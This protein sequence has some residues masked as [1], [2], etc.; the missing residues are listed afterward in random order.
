[1]QRSKRRFGLT[2]AM[3]IAAGAGLS[4]GEA[5]AQAPS[6]LP[7][8]SIYRRPTISPYNQISNFAMNPMQFQKVYQ[9]MV[10]PQMQQQQQLLPHQQLI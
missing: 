10:V 7:F 5:R 4:G 1:M 3:V 6:N 8:S 2:A 9:Q